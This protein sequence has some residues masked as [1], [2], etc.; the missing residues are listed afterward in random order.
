[1]NKRSLVGYSPWDHKE[2]DMTGHDLETEHAH[3]RGR[4]GGRK[5]AWV[6]C[7]TDMVQIR[8]TSGD[9]KINFKLNKFNRK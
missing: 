5:E 8:K 9:E 7:C 3:S 6:L 4:E 1:M 2:S